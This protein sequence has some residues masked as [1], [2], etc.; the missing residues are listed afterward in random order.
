MIEKCFFALKYISELFVH[1]VHGGFYYKD[2]IFE[3]VR[4]VV[5]H[6]E[7]VIS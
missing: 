4:K 1:D 3:H 7:R 2:I 6:C 5:V